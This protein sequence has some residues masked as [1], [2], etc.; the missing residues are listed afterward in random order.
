MVTYRFSGLYYDPSQSSLTKEMWAALDDRS[1]TYGVR[2]CPG[3]VC[4]SHVC[5][6]IACVGC[7]VE[8]H[9]RQ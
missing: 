5:G 7:G 4:G 6:Y 2:C 3:N 9:K 1:R 8:M